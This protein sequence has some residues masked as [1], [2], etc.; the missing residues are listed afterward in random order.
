[1]DLSNVRS[2]D[3]CAAITLIDASADLER[4]FALFAVRR[5]PEVI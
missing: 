4:A 1:V 3:K 2:T 5:S